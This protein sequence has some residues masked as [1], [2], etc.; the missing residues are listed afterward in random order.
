MFEE[1]KLDFN[2]SIV[3]KEVEKMILDI[4]DYLHEK[5]EHEHTCKACNQKF[6]IQFKYDEFKGRVF[7]FVKCNNLC[8]NEISVRDR[9][10]ILK[11]LDYKYF[12]CY[13]CFSFTIFDYVSY[14]K[15]I[16]SECEDIKFKCPLLCNAELSK[17]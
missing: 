14:F 17:F 16:M 1:L 7:C 15:H 13:R 2:S 5:F 10:A 9:L 3:Q 8:D 11:S 6:A 4:N 12:N